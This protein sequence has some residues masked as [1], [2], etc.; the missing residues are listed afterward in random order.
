MLEK[1]E[2]LPAGVIGYRATGHVTADDYRDVLVPALRE[3]AEV[4]KIRLVFEIG[5]GFEEFELGAL[6][7]DAR[8][9]IT[10][11]IGHHSAWKRCALVTDLD[12]MAKAMHAFAWLAPGEVRTFAPSELDDAKEWAGA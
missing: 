1:L 10:L 6:V 4:G 3:Q 2:E 11:G 12:W 9:G 8:T 5:P 7:Q